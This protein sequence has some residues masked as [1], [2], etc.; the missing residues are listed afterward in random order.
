MAVIVNIILTVTMFTK[1]M[2]SPFSSWPRTLR[3]CREL[4]YAGSS[5]RD[6]TTGDTF[7]KQGAQSWEKERKINML[8]SITMSWGVDMPDK[9]H[10]DTIR[11]DKAE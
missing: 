6:D 10:Y 1:L 4:C 5:T 7:R 2:S 9:M 3:L 11:Y 8:Q